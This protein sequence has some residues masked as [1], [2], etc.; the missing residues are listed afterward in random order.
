VLTAGRVFPTVAPLPATPDRL[1]FASTHHSLSGR[2]LAFWRR[3]HGDILLG[4]P[5]AEPTHEQNNDGSGR[6][7]LVQWFENGRL[8]YHPEFA[9]TRYEVELGLTGKQDL[10]R[11]GWLSQGRPAAQAPATQVGAQARRGP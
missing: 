3:R 9:G 10:Q 8:E 5:I 6:T 11:R 2:F 1:Y 4:A 7:Y